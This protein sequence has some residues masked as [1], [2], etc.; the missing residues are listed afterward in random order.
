LLRHTEELRMIIRPAE[1]E[2][3]TAVLRVE[4]AAFGRAEE[5]ELV[6]ALLEDPTAAPHVSLLAE[7]DGTP[8]GLRA[9]YAIDPA[10]ADAWMVCETRPGLL[11]VVRGTVGCADGLM[12]PA[13][14]RE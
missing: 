11:G 6:A 3:L 2:D 10:V 13:L 12:N 1:P 14:W 8:I 9:P 4:R 7:A 5:A